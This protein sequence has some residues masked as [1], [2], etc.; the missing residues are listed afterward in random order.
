MCGIAGFSFSSRKNDIV[1]DVKKTIE[2]MNNSLSH[3]GPDAFGSWISDDKNRIPLKAEVAM[4]VGNVEL[5]IK[6]HKGLRYP[7]N[8]K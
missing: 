1:F 5:D 2:K 4:F 7:L 3:R 8:K 6:E